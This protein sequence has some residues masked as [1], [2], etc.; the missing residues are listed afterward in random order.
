MIAALEK[1]IDDLRAQLPGRAIRWVHA[2]GIH[3]TLKFLG[4]VAPEAL[5]DIRAA[6]EA[7]V[8]DS[9][10]FDLRAVGLGCFP[11]NQRP[12]VIWVGLDGQQDALHRLRDAIEAR[13]SPLG[14]PTEKRAFNPHLTL[15]RVKSAK[16]GELSAVARV[17]E[18]VSANEL[19]R[20]TAQTVSI[21]QS[22]LKPD[23]AV[24]TA[25]AKYDL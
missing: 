17:I 7:A 19:A 4:D 13:V 16:A 15:G 10:P 2:Q 6:T 25:L 9:G 11:N 24:Y 5:A 3:L 18:G 12:R 8:I 14:F 21:I 20:W 22:T 23:G 1:Q